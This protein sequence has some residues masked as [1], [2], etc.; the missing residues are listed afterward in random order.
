MRLNRNNAQFRDRDRMGLSGRSAS[1]QDEPC[2]HFWR[3]LVG[4][5]QLP[6]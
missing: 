2:L 3:E 6:L 5:R 1:G 4:E